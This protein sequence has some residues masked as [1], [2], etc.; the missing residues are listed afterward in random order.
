MATGFDLVAS[1]STDSGASARACN[2]RNWR[3]PTLGKT[4]A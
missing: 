3:K 1:V 2:E 4:D